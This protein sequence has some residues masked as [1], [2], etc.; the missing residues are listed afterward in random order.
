MDINYFLLLRGKY[1]TILSYIDSIIDEFDTCKECLTNDTFD[2]LFNS[3]ENK[4]FFVERKNHILQLKD[5][6]NTNIQNICIHEFIEDVIDID[7]DVSKTI[8]Y[9]K[10]CEFTRQ[11]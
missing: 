10:F 9:C 6:C 11:L 3:E 2:T 5:L 7:P 4:H 8:S 1:T